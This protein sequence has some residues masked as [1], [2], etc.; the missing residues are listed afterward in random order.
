MQHSL[1][2]GTIFYMTQELDSIRA[3]LR[4]RLPDLQRRYRVRSLWLFGSYVRGAQRRRSDVDVLIE[5]DET[6]SLLQLARLQ[7]ELSQ[8]L[9][10]R[11]DIALKHTLKPHLGKR[12]LEEAIPI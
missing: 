8:I 10:K 9:R 1:D 7:R 11:V 4:E 12:I 5:F 3:V 2:S 6:P